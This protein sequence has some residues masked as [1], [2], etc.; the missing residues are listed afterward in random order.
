MSEEKELKPIKY[1][2]FRSFPSRLYAEMLQK[3]LEKE[4][5]PS[6]IKSDDVG[7]MLGSY[8]TISPVEVM[9]WVPEEDFEKCAKIADEM[10]NH[11]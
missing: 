5:I 8:S 10:L 6:I 4:G 9:V 7:I 1:I 3:A 11:I 2:P